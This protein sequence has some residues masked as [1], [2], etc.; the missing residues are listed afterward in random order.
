M[1]END[2]PA[3]A[4]PSCPHRVVLVEPELPENIGF[5]VRA[6]SCFGLS[7][8]VLVG[9]PRPEPDSPAFRTAT[10]GKEILAAAEE[11]ATLR[12]A[13]GDARTTVAF[14]R[15][16][17]R[18]ALVPLPRLT[19]ESGLHEAPW[20]LVFG[21]E[22]IG[23]TSEEV[24][25]CDIACNIPTHHP[26]GSLN[27]GQAASIAMA[28]LQAAPPRR[29]AGDGEGTALAAKREEWVAWAAAEIEARGL[30]HPARLD[31]GR[32]HLSDLLRRL[33][34]SDGELRFLEGISRKIS[35]AD[36]SQPR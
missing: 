4:L 21:R 2:A 24:L 14:T 27:L 30:L 9:C 3:G 17:H 26:T 8:L 11:A 32:K 22:S 35:R 29:S 5:V 34:P 28:F 15:R 6:M 20:A 33:R 18:T 13:F 16:P 25:A 31:A 12:E 10:L 36:P 19:Q 7:R 1:P 23:L